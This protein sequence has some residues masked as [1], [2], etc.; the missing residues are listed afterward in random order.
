[1]AGGHIPRTWLSHTAQFGG[2]EGTSNG[3]IRYTRW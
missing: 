1:M 3:D 2:K